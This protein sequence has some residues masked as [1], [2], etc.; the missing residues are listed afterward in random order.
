MSEDGQARL[1]LCKGRYRA[2]FAQSAADLALA[3]ELRHRAFHGG[4]PGRDED[5]FDPL[6]RHV[7]I[8][9]S[10]ELICCF[11]LLELESGAE[12]KRSYSAQYYDLVRL[13]AYPGKVME[14]GRFC[15]TPARRDPD[16]LRLAWAALTRL[17]D[18]RGIDLLF[19][20]SS[21]PGT[22][23]R[24][25]QA[26]LTALRR[27]NLAP[28]HWA[29]QPR[30]A[31]IVPLPEGPDPDPLAAARNLPPLLRS[32]LSMGGW[33]SDHAVIDRDLNTLHVFTGLEI[34]AIPPAR[35]RLLRA[36]AEEG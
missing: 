25:H 33:V 23:P 36:I 26:A 15:V 31:L 1:E 30:A 11:R 27:H 24:P 17:V 12:I 18:G 3:Q 2:R 21:F 7:L 6:C 9:A 19:G 8:E 34:A 4:A 10:G 35:A 22:D 20:C 13:T 28:A 16:I 29:P 14:I 32:Y 5:A